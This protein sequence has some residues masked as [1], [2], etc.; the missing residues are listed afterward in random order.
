VVTTILA[1]Y[2]SFD[3]LGEATVVF[4]AA[5]AVALVLRQGLVRRRRPDP[6]PGQSSAPD[7]DRAAP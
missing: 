6:E 5:L 2:R 3:T 1:D 7:P 4:T